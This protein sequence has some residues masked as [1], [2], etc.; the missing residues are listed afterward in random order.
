[1]R[2]AA[3]IDLS[4]VYSPHQGQLDIHMSP[5]KTK[6]LHI[7]RRW[8]KSRFALFEALKHYAHSLERPVDRSLVPPFHA[9]IVAPTDAQSN[10]LW[11]ELVSFVPEELVNDYPMGIHQETKRIWLR[12]R[13]KA[14]QWGLIEVKTAY[15]FNALQTVGLDYL[16]VTEA[17]DVDERAFEKLLPT[18]RTPGRLSYAVYEGIP[19]LVNSHWF[20]RVR[21]MGEDGE[22]GYEFFHAT[23][24]DN[25]LLNEEQ[26]AEIEQDRKLLRAAAWERMYLATFSEEAGF[27]NNIAACTRGDLLPAPV[28]G[29]NY[30]AGVDLAR[31]RDATVI[32]VFDADDRRVV[33]HKRFDGGEKWITQ[34]ET[35]ASL[36]ETWGLQR[37]MVDATTMGGD[38]FVE[39]LEGMAVPV[40]SY[41]VSVASR[42]PLLNG[43]AVALERET[44]HFPPVEQLIRELRA[45][46][47]RKTS[48]GA[49][50]AMAPQG[51]HD[52]EVFALALGLNACKPPAELRGVFRGASGR[53]YFPR[54]GEGGSYGRR[55]MRDRRVERM[56]KR[57]EAAGI[58]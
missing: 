53:R 20:Q 52:D 14:G 34:R 54:D 46:Q 41:Y 1:V 44:V 23:Y 39:E 29:R 38:M 33:Y 11:N 2:G 56:R 27:F 4:K 21:R 49:W 45:F 30:V 3:L 55:L 32:L 58:K 48:S 26:K 43:L 7:G 42:E 13:E 22:P 6:V 28:D 10:Q 35:I 8:G 17:Q 5:A 12:G 47:H 19:P 40:E 36:T 9:W 25:P 37:V 31:K 51:E 57:M 16:W 18:L 15:N 24:K 50:K